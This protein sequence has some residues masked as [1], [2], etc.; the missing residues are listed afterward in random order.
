PGCKDGQ[1]F[2]LG[3]YGM[4]RLNASYRGDLFVTVS[5]FVPQKISSKEKHF[6][7]EYSELMAEEQSSFWKKLF[8]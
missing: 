5:I 6:L 3:G 4:P 8:K 7:E 1:V 2:R